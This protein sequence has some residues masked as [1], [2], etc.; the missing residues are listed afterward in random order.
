MSAVEIFNYAG[1]KVRTVV[2]DGEPWFVGK[3]ITDVLGI[4][5]QRDAFT[6]LDADE[7]ITVALPDG[8][9]GNPNRT[10]VNEAGL[11][12]LILRSDKPEARAFK[13]WVTHEVLP[14][15]RRTGQFRPVEVEHALPQSYAD[16]LR[17][18]AAKV[19]HVQALEAK[20]AEDA[21]KVEAF[22]RWM[23]A[24]GYYPMHAVAKI[25]GLGRNNL[26][27]MLRDAG[28][29]MAVGTAPYQRYAHHFAIIPGVSRDGFAYETTKV[30]PTGIPFIAKKLGIA[31]TQEAH[32]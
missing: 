17:E 28:V 3:D 18:L 6:R 27:A 25:L 21:P 10:V 1:A 23:D 12:S 30:R 20:A 15:I 19:E 32:A 24:D 29:I 11:Y 16:A 26:Y 2:I 7:R 5:N 22:D 4:V 31:L 8:N 9:R 13:R 14:Q